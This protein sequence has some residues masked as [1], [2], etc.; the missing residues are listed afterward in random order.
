M[1]LNPFAI[2]MGNKEAVR[3]VKIG[4]YTTFIQLKV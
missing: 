2:S 1:P 3:N 4:K